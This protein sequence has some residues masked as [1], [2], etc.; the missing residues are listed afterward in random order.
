MP[1]QAAL[2]IALDQRA[3]F[4]IPLERFRDWYGL[5]PD[6]ALRGLNQLQSFGVLDSEA[7]WREEPLSPTGNTKEV[8]YALQ[9]PFRH[10]HGPG[11]SATPA[12]P[13]G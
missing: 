8:R 7:E 2:L 10:T 4:S 13:I 9:P 5:S 1:A 6:T 3:G 11:R 12:A